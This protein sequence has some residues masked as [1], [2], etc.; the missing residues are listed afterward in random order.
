MVDIT[1]KLVGL[2][3]P[4]INVDASGSS[5]TTG[6]GEQGKALGVAIQ[7]AVMDTL[8]REQRPGGVLGGG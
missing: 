1:A 3:Q 8:Q 7:A 2:T 6:N 5:S 4:T